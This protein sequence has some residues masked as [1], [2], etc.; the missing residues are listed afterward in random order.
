MAAAPE[1][2]KAIMDDPAWPRGLV[3]NLTE[4][5]RPGAE[6]WADEGMALTLEWDIDPADVRCSVTWWH[7]EHDA[8][9]PLA[10]VRRVLERMQ[11][12]DLR[13]WTEAG[14]LKPYLQHDEILAELLTR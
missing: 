2:D 10:A 8:N 3:E 1:S 6:G 13:V 14:H 7:G 11:D 12:V 9:A 5:L 4:A